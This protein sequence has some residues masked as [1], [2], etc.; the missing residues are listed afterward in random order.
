MA[1]RIRYSELESR[2]ARDRL[3]P[4]KYHHRAL[5]PGKLA[6]GYRRAQKSLPGIWYK[7]E[8]MGTDAR[9]IGRYRATQL[10]LADDYADADGVN[11]LSYAQALTKAQET[12]KPNRS[13]VTVE[14]A[15]RAYI[16]WLKAHRATGDD[17]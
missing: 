2:A 16:K 4:G 5:A 15:L 6:I 1:R 13:T 14:D 11:V 9:G 10:G 7:R 17:A 12:G 8:Y 3:R